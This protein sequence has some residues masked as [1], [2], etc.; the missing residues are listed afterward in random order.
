MDVLATSSHGR[1]VILYADND[2]FTPNC[3]RVMVDCGF[4]KLYLQWDTAGTARYVKNAAIWLLGLE[5][6]LATD[7]PITGAI[8]VNEQEAKPVWQYQHGTWHNYDEDANDVVEQAY[9]EWK[10]NPYTDVRAVKSGTWSYSVNFKEMVQTNVVHDN[11]TQ[12]PI[13]RVEEKVSV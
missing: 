11:H 12:R 6:R 13:R 10:S 2:K 5:H 1:P 8:A 9:Q 4:T 3:G 7:A